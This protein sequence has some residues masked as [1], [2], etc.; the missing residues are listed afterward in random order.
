[1]WS[2]FIWLDLK[3]DSG[4]DAPLF[5]FQRWKSEAQDHK[6]CI[7]GDA[8]SQWR[9]CGLSPNILT[10]SPGLFPPP[11]N[12][13]FQAKGPPLL[14]L[15]DWHKVISLSYQGVY[16]NEIKESALRQGPLMRPRG[17]VWGRRHPCAGTRSFPSLSNLS[18]ALPSSSPALPS[19]SPARLVYISSLFLSPLS[20][21]FL[22][23]VEFHSK[24]PHRSLHLSVERSTHWTDDLGKRLKLLVQ[25]F[26]SLLSG[27]S[28]HPSSEL[29]QAPST[30][31]P[32]ELNWGRWGKVSSRE[33]EKQQAHLTHF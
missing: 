24:Q 20:F 32:R 13:V 31:Q 23:R 11:W 17:R 14:I 3:D 8:R 21:H 10:P 22:P 6:G 29:P 2:D 19:S 18:P 1:M 25:A 33:R 27:L 26:L 12:T 16:F 7:P 9:G 28:V 4:E 15:L 5:P 30:L